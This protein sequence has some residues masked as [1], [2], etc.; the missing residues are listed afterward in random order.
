M[1]TISEYL[2]YA[3]TAFAAYAVSLTPGKGNTQ[4]YIAEK[5]SRPQAEQF[6]KTWQVLGQSDPSLAN[7][8]SAVL[9]QPVDANGNP[10]GQKVLAI[11]GTET[12][13]WLVD[14]RVDVVDIALTGTAA[15]MSQY[16]SLERFYQSLIAGGRL[17]GSENIVVTGH[18][19]FGEADTDQWWAGQ[20]L[21]PAKSRRRR[22]GEYPSRN[23]TNN[24]WRN[25]A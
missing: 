23:C 12:S 22:D 10:A 21:G 25:A 6:D 19:L 11:R 4:K 1:P 17:G 9:L 7:G 8:F 20:L 2:K 18:I 14:W 15:G 5:M 13:H 3:E 24:L 16:A